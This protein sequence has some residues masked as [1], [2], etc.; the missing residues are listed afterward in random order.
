MKR[1]ILIL[2]AL[3]LA[4]AASGCADKSDTEYEVN[5]IKDGSFEGD[6]YEYWDKDVWVSIEGFS[7]F[8]V[9]DENGNHVLKIESREMNDAKMKQT[10]DVEEKEIYKLSGYVKAE[11]AMNGTGANLSFE[12]MFFYTDALFDTN[13]EYVYVEMYGKTAKGQEQLTVF[14]R[15]GGYSNESIGTA[16]FDD[17]RLEKVKEA[18]EGAKVYTLEESK[19]AKRQTQVEEDDEDKVKFAGM[20]TL[21]S[22]AFIVAFLMIKQSLDYGDALIKD[23]YSSVYLSIFGVI[24]TFGLLV[25]AVLAATVAGYPNDIGCWIGWSSAAADRGIAGLYDGTT[26]IDYPP[27]YMYILYF[28]GL[29]NKI[30]LVGQAAAATV[31]IPPILA[32]V[33]MTMIIYKVAKEKLSEKAALLL[34]SLYF[35]SPAIITDSSAWGQIDSIL[36]IMGVLFIM[37]M[38]KKDKKSFILAGV[39]LGA[40][41]LIKPQMLFFAPLYILGSFHLLKDDNSIESW[42]KIIFGVIAGIAA[43]IILTLPLI[44]GYG[45]KFVIDLMINIV[46]SYGSVSLNAANLWALLGGMWEKVETP[47][48]GS[49]YGVWGYIGLALS[50]VIF[51]VVAFRDKNH[52]NIFFHT[53]LLITGIFI[54][55]GKMHERYMYPAMALLL[56]SYIYTKDRRHLSLFGWFTVTQFANTSLVLANKYIFGFRLGGFTKTMIDAEN[57]LSWLKE[58]Q[59]NLWT[60]FISIAAVLGY[61]LMIYIGLKKPDIEKQNE[62]DEIIKE[63]RKEIESNKKEKIIEDINSEEY[64]GLFKSL[65]KKDYIIMLSLTVIYGIIAFIH[66]GNSY[67]PE[68]M[69]NAITTNEEVVVD[70]GKDVEIDKIMFFRAQGTNGANFTVDFAS[71]NNDEEYYTSYYYR[72]DEEGR[73]ENLRD[74]IISEYNLTDESVMEFSNYPAIFK[75][76]E[77]DGYDIARY[78]RITVHRPMLRLVEMVFVDPEGNAIPIKDIIITDPDSSEAVNLFDEQETVP[79]KRTYMNSTYFDEIYHAGTAWEHLMRYN[80]YETTHPPLGKVIMSLGIKM[81]GMNPFGWRF[82]GTIIGILMVP[83]MYLLAMVIF[84]KTRYAWIAT[85]LMTFD[86]MH[87]TQTRIATIDSY[88]VFFIML[89]FLCM[90][91]YFRMSFYKSKFIKTLIPLF[92][93]GL[94]FGLGAASKWI[95]LYAGAGLAVVFFYTL[96]KRYR[97]YLFVWKHENEDVG[98][99]EEKSSFIKKKY[100]KYII[101]TVALC[102]IFFI[103]IPVCIYTASYIPILQAEE[104]RGLEYVVESQKYM[105]NYHSGLNAEHSFASPWYEWPF[106][107]KPMWYYSDP[108]LNDTGR[109]ASI[110]AF[111]NPAVWWIGTI[112]CIWLIISLFRSKKAD[113]IKIFIIIGFLA[114]YMP[115]ILVPRSMFIYHYFASV[116]FI[117]IMI[118]MMIRWLENKKRTFIDEDGNVYEKAFY[119]RNITYVY[120]GIVIALFIFFYPVTAGVEIP[121]EYGRLLKWLPSWWFTYS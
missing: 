23:D 6:L 118:T 39:M 108:T 78:A 116:P 121:A 92:L 10:V 115:W 11:N 59:M 13:G 44:I 71:T 80:P 50:V 87:M 36:A 26:F 52:K 7:K 12:N 47:F 27:G 89:M 8:N 112:A 14:A 42:K 40:G 86:F 60:S 49:T 97:E 110:A 29:L 30:P 3:I 106:I 20:M 67:G 61:I 5:L 70:F 28:V 74:Q 54:L 2:A 31:K 111:G 21:L 19:P 96:Y 64:K 117:I 62:I 53:A 72:I 45:A 84:M 94:F 63:E 100:R 88:G 46:S 99:D 43:F 65:K 33:A 105:F 41:V 95:C 24:I 79:E 51:A 16:Y 34:S 114:Q 75:W 73:L 9:A 68:T 120:I 109:M 66:L 77:M 17:I 58:N 48:L 25:R 22:I 82:M 101:I 85:V 83:V 76:Y 18:P 107:V 15:L 103:V 90:G 1:I 56:F 55:S 32:D 37:F 57:F 113:D 104:G 35:L 93:S 81:F 38:H 119:N 69:W 91:I 4:V 98:I 102:I